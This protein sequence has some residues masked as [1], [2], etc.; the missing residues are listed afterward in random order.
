ME[1]VEQVVA[2]KGALALNEILRCRVRYFTDGAIFGSRAFVED[3]FQ[4]HREHFSVR[5]EEGARPL[6]GGVWGD[7]FTARQ[8]RVNVM[9]DPAPA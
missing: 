6:K 1:A 9:G 3:A 2:L 7:L 4:R 8:L 5:R